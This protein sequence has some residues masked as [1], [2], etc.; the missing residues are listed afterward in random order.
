MYL[1]TT[2]NGYSDT[3]VGGMELFAHFFTPRNIEITTGKEEKGTAVSHKSFM[4]TRETKNKKWGVTSPKLNQVFT[5][6]G[7]WMGS[8]MRTNPNSIQSKKHPLIPHCR[9]TS[10]NTLHTHTTNTILTD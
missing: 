7:K 1:D 6:K 3:V 10:H 8:V 5:W 2:R 9:A 4:T